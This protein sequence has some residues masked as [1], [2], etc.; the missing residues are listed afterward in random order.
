MPPDDNMDLFVIYCQH[1]HRSPILHRRN[2]LQGTVNL[3]LFV[4]FHKVISNTHSFIRENFTNI[5]NYIL[6]RL[7]CQPYA[8]N[9]IFYCVLI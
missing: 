7:C 3:S 9:L 6:F 5:V 1:N 4:L 8:T 2:A